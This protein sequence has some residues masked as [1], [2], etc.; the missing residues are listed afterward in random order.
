MTVDLV[1][2]LRERLDEDAQAAKHAATREPHGASWN[3][4][5]SDG[6]EVRAASGVGVVRRTWPY[7]ATHIARHD[8]ARVL[9]E[10][11]AKRRIV[12]KCEEHMQLDRET[13]EAEK[14][15]ARSLSSL[16]AAYWDACRDLA[17][18]YA[19]HPDYYEE[20]RP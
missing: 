5:D 11:D 14:E 12:S 4:T 20:W 1:A 10:V 8:P 17:S 15:P 13:F 18:A 7:A 2:F 6:S 19:D 3:V 9:A 16:R